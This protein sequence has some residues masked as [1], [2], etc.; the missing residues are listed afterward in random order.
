MHIAI[1][2]S[3]APAAN[4]TPGPGPL[5]KDIVLGPVFALEKARR[6]AETLTTIGQNRTLTPKKSES[7]NCELYIASSLPFFTESDE[8][9][10]RK[11]RGGM[12][13]Q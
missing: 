6:T 13:S 1:G 12:Q 3:A 10:E 2:P 4:Q 11:K 7:F 9:N 5:L 8:P